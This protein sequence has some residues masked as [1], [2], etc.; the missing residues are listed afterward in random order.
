MEKKRIEAVLF[1]IG[2]RIEDHE[3]AAHVKLDLESTKKILHELKI[4]YEQ[5]D[6]AF[7]LS[8]QA[9]TWKLTVGERYMDTV[10]NIMPH[11][12]LSR[13]IMES[14][15]VIAW[16]AP[17]LQSDV[18]N[19][20]GN[21]AYEH[22][23]E[24]V[25]MG[26][27]SKTPHGRSYTIKLAQRFFEYFDLKDKEAVKERFGN[28]KDV[29]EEDIILKDLEEQGMEPYDEKLGDLQVYDE[30]ESEKSKEQESTRVEVVEPAVE[31]PHLEVVDYPEKDETTNDKQDDE[32]SSPEESSD[33]S[34][35]E[36]LEESEDSVESEE[37]DELE[38]NSDETEAHDESEQSDPDEDTKAKTDPEN[39]D[40][41]DKEKNQ[42]S[43]SQDGSS[44]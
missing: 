9:N 21:K 43:D 42:E 27:I 4:D 31:Q 11:T 29:S 25:D 33:Q 16:K 2:D 24:L 40:A 1:A 38:E 36:K 13:A 8:N 30:P 20:R 7:I 19:T 26:Y 37:T 12:E 32:S 39:T 14:L 28:F 34:E 23:K 3:I 17:V 15:A 35:S 10:Q 41:K 18:I 22:I 6:S 44:S 5:K